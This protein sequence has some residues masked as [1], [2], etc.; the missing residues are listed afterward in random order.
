MRSE[1]VSKVACNG[2]QTYLLSS[3]DSCITNYNIRVGHLF[4]AKWV[5]VVYSTGSK[6]IPRSI[7]EYGEC[8]SSRSS[9]TSATQQPAWIRASDNWTRMSLFSVMFAWKSRFTSRTSSWRRNDHPL[10][11]STL[12]LSFLEWRV[13]A[14]D[15]MQTAYFSHSNRWIGEWP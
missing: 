1:R 15:G 7:E 10:R 4:V 3:E 6:L 11:G 5:T 13:A 12:P 14:T 8:K 2:C 9:F